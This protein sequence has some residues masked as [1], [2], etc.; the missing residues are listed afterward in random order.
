MF[1]SRR[2]SLF[3]EVLSLGMVKIQVHKSKLLAGQRSSDRWDLREVSSSNL[4]SVNA[5]MGNIVHVSTLDVVSNRSV[6]Q[7]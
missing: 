4:D 6:M 5:V 1:L 3:L 2:H 7:Q